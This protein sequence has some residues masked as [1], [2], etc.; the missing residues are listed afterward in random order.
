MYPT[1]LRIYMTAV[2]AV[3]VV[4]ISKYFGVLLH[5]SITMGIFAIGVLLG[6]IFAIHFE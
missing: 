6:T 1:R 2:C 3:A 5:P 4:L